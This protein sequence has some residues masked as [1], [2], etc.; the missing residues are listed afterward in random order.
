MATGSSRQGCSGG[1]V[2]DRTAS[3]EAWLVVLP[4]VDWQG[5]S[6]EDR[7]AS[8]EAWLVVLS[9]ADWL[10]ERAGRVAVVLLLER[11]FHLVFDS[12]VTNC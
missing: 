5:C 1:G 3:V 2:E 12:G 4:V 7:T 6:V 10:V 8:V 11:K 9:V